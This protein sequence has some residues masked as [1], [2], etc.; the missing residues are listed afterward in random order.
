MPITQSQIDA[1]DA[2]IA[3][4]ERAVRSQHGTVEYRSVDELIKARNALAAQ[5]EAEQAQAGTVTPRRRIFRLF[6]AGRGYD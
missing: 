3:S 4:G 1:L 5:M 6:H 2:A